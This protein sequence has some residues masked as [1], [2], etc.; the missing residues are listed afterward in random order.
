M[1]YCLATQCISLLSQALFVHDV[2]AHDVHVHEQC[3]DNQSA[4]LRLALELPNQVLVASAIMGVPW[5][6]FLFSW[7]GYTGW[8]SALS[9]WRHLQ[10]FRT[11]LMARDLKA[12]V[13]VALTWHTPFTKAQESLPVVT[14]M[15]GRAS[16]YAVGR[17]PCIDQLLP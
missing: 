8:Y 17:S 12:A 7:C 16:T 4:G 5:M 1:A 10:V 11:G 6:S 3:F 2:H 13:T 14:I 15:T 9:D